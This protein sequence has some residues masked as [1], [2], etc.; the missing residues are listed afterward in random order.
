MVPARCWPKRPRELSDSTI[1]ITAS[2]AQLRTKTQ[3][4]HTT[5]VQ[6]Y[7]G[8][9][10][11]RLCRDVGTVRQLRPAGVQAVLSLQAKE[12]KRAGGCAPQRGSAVAVPLGAVVRDACAFAKPKSAARAAC[13]RRSARFENSFSARWYYPITLLSW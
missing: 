7:H 13:A 5:R 9:V 8:R 12:Q 6:Y 1:R 4:F 2:V 10:A 11:P 3:I